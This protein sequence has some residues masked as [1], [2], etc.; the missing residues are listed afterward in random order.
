[1]ILIRIFTWRQHQT[2][3]VALLL[4]ASFLVLA[5]TPALASSRSVVAPATGQCEAYARWAGLQGTRKAYAY[6]SWNVSSPMSYT[7]AD[8][9]NGTYSGSQPVVAT[10]N[11]S[12]VNGWTS[13]AS[14]S[15]YQ[16]SGSGW[17]WCDGR[18]T[19]SSSGGYAYAFASCPTAST[20][21]STRNL[22][23][24]RVWVAGNPV[25]APLTAT[26]ISRYP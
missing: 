19:S 11:C 3:L 23:G 7:S 24:H 9:Y 25:D 14:T 2:L 13:E 16:S 18:F 17:V 5:V 21:L 4:V 10:A 1:M 22:H 15:L 26:D 6:I 20:Q 8:T 12:G